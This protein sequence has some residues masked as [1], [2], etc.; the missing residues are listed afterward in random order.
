M[1]GDPPL[2]YWAFISYSHRDR[3]WADWLH[4]R[5]E[6]YRVPRQI[7]GGAV[8]TRV[9]PVFR[10]RDELSSA[11]DL[12]G[13]VV[14]ALGDSRN[15]VVICSPEAVRSRWVNEEIRHFLRLGRQDRVF[16][17][18][19]AGHPEAGD[20][21]PPALTEQGTE[22]VAAD[23]RD[24]G[25]GKKNAF[26]KLM[27]GVLGVEFDKLRRREYERQ[28]RTRTIWTTALIVL[29]AILGTLS[30]Y[31]NW[32]RLVAIERQK[33]ATSRMLATE[34]LGQMRTESRSIA[35]VRH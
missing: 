24:V 11:A 26:L 29:A 2:K 27:A 25:D 15:L 22:P 30:L 13:K 7:V 17:F 3:R 12:T 19:V 6:T 33:I 16:A 23:A 35:P 34:A 10:D 21:F 5:M 31:A 14:T 9:F 32:Q 1:T 28:L 8:P 18:I 20:C 4:K